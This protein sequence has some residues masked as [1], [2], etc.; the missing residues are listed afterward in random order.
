MNLLWLSISSGQGLG[1]SKQRNRSQVFASPCQRQYTGCAPA[2]CDRDLL[3]TVL[4]FS[5]LVTLSHSYEILLLCSCV[6]LQALRQHRFSVPIH[7]KTDLQVVMLF[8]S[9]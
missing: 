7:A 9:R 2:V 6:G 8:R 1:A 4:L 5:R 3:S